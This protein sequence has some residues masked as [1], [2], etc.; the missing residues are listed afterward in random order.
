MCPY[1]HTA[2]LHTGQVPKIFF[3]DFYLFSSNLAFYND[4]KKNFFLDFRILS[5]KFRF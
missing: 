3:K 4:L 5:K 2:N 1:G